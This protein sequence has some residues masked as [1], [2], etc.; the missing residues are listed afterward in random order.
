MWISKVTMP[1]PAEDDI[2]QSL[3][4]IIEAM[5]EP[6]EAVGGYKQPDMVPV[7]AEW[8]GYRAGATKKSVELKISEEEKYK[9][10]MKEV[11]S[12]TT[13]LYFH[14]GAHYLMDPSSHRPTCKKLAKI[15]KG[16]CL[17]VRYRLAPQN[18]FPSALIDALVSYFTLLY[19]PPGSLHT[20]VAPENIVLAGD[21]AGG[22]L[23]LSLL[24]TILQFR[25]LN[26]TP[27]FHGSPREVPLP[28]GCATASPWC[29]IT[30]SLPSHTT[31]APYDY[32][33][34]KLARPVFGQVYPS[35]DIWPSSPPRKVFYADDGLLLHPLVSPVRAG[36]WKGACPLYVAV[37]QELLSDEGKVLVK[38]A[39]G[40]GVP[41]V[42]DE[43]EA[44][45]HCFG[46]I[47]EGLEGSRRFFDGWGGFFSKV[48]GGGLAGGEKGGVVSKGTYIAAKTLEE[49][50]LDLSTLS[51]LKEEEIKEMMQE[52]ADK[53]RIAEGD[54]LAAKL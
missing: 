6:G 32:L 10:L 37:G 7:E 33:P 51:E 40:Q 16:R 35:C 11:S 2:R 29:D 43:F 49:R 53:I 18:P 27:L 1:A 36:D 41:V 12:P 52:A 15:T 45:P 54:P 30:M 50:N 34:G 25:R 24:Q 4:Q 47:F 26:I 23:A 20:A 31:N 21:S 13:I 8:T 3:F 44:M 42:F 9:E 19:P 38:R 48:S 5:K 22:N 14:G 17:S 39:S 46:M 28:A